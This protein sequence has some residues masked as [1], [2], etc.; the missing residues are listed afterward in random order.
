LT[1]KDRGKF[2]AASRGGIKVI[3]QPCSPR[4][5]ACARDVRAIGVID[6][7]CDGDFAIALA[8]SSGDAT[9]KASSP[10]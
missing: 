10:R 5:V 8:V 9:A 3:A 6:D 4:L 7:F 1:L 2:V